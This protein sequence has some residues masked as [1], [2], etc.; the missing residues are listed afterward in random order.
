M[1][2][3]A[4][5]RPTFDSPPIRPVCAGRTRAGPFD[6]G[7]DRVWERA[8]IDA[9]LPPEGTADVEVALARRRRST[10]ARRMVR[11]PSPDALLAASPAAAAASSGC[12]CASH[13]FG[14]ATPPVRQLRCATAAE[15]Y[16]DYLPL[17]YRRNDHD[18]FLSRWL[19]LLRGEFGASKSRST[20]CRAW[21]IPQFA[22]PASIDW[23]AQWF[24]LEL[25]Q[26]ADDDEARALISPRAAALRAARHAASIARVRRAAHRHPPGDRRGVRQTRRIWV[27][28]VSSRLDFDT[29]L[30]AGSIPGMVVPDAAPTGAAAR[31]PS[32]VR[33]W[34]RAARWRRIR[35]ACR[36]SPTRPIASASSSDAYRVRDP[37][38]CWPSCSAS[39]TA[40]SRRIPTIGV[41]L[42][43]PGT[44]RRIPSRAS[45]STPIVGGDHRTVRSMQALLGYRNSR[46]PRDDVARVGDASLDGTLYLELR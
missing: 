26:I 32:A 7:E 43:A 40:K 35:S 33:S 16:L 11:L 29:R 21:P 18:G 6:A 45:A 20:R 38:S 8:W 27:L 15:D 2:N 10:A 13:D 24:G 5:T 28:G 31:A 41:E 9:E 17:T 4:S 42:V 39:S 22:P 3:P 37:G 44:A 12:G 25:P 46:L 30:A 23:L 34:A 19:K 1:S 36:F 14:A